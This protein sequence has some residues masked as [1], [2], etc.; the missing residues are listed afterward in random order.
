M[1]AAAAPLSPRASAVEEKLRAWRL[2]EAKEH[3]VPAFCVLGN[4]TLRAIAERLPKTHQELLSVSG[5]GSA[6]A[7]KFGEK[8]CRIC[9]SG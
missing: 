6:K 9:A 8:I 5:I 2:A 4:K 3:G 1:Q 7:E